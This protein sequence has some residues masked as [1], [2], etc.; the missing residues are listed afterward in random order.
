MNQLRKQFSTIALII[1]V[2]PFVTLMTLHMQ[3]A[4]AAG[5]TIVIDDVSAIS[6]Y[7]IEVQVEITL[8]GFNYDFY[9]QYLRLYLNKS[10]NTIIGNN[11]DDYNSSKTLSRQSTT[12]FETYINSPSLS[13]GSHLD[14]ANYNVTVLAITNTDEKSSLV[15][16]TGGYIFIDTGLPTIT[17][18]DPITPYQEVWGNFTVKAKIQDVSNLHLIEFYVGTILKYTIHEP[19]GSQTVFTWNWICLKTEIGTQ[20]AVK[21]KAQDNSSNL[22]TD[23]KSLSVKVV[24][25][26]IDYSKTPPSYIDSNNTL[27]LEV[28]V[29]DALHTVSSVIVRYSLNDT[30]WIND[31]MT[32]LTSNKYNYTFPTQPVGTKI[33]WYFI[34]NNSLNQ[35]NIFLNTKLL[36]FSIYSVYPDHI[37][38][39]GKITHEN[40]ITYGNPILI[41][42]NVTEQS[43]INLCYM[44]YKF[45]NSAVWEQVDMTFN[46]TGDLESP[47]P[48]NKW[49]TYYHE[50][51]ANYSIFTIITFYIWLNDSGNN[52][53]QLDNN[54]NYYTVKVIPNDLIAP[55]ITIIS[56]PDKLKTYQNITVIVEINE[57]S[58]LIAVKLMFI[59]DDK[60]YSLDMIH[61]SSNRWS[62][63]FILNATTGKNVRIWVRAIDKFYNTGDSEIKQYVVESEKI[64]VSHNNFVIVL[65]LIILA[66][67]LPIVLTLVVLKPQ[68]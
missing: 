35:Y 14:S 26:K 13:N 49:Y 24:G 41:K 47:G 1:M 5:P 7:K 10:I 18:I 61:V 68:K 38:P 4:K 16:W 62:I 52:I 67:I 64:G 34:A 15:Q 20:P 22:N 37:K 12:T 2:L 28:V 6:S 59:I 53:L 19:N 11:Y 46:T 17:F 21:I 23:T 8:V 44:K 55:N 31:S 27:K 9:T 58:T 48:D 56:I 65:L 29:T 30:A 63:S 43:P 57:T 40:Q 51:D 33:S 60:Q 25:P 32:Y 36:P 66:V 39:I 42:L 50:F 3:N 45:N 54:G